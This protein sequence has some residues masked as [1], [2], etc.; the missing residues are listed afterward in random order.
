MGHHGVFLRHM[1]LSLP[2]RALAVLL[3]LAVS[4]TAAEPRYRGNAKSRVY[5]HSSCRYF[6]CTNCTVQL[7]ST[8]EAAARGFRACGICGKPRS[9]KKQE[10]A[11]TLSGNAKTRKFHRA[12]CRYA[13]CANCTAK[14]KTRQQAIEAGF[15]AGGCCNP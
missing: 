1:T 14:F 13:S 2:R 11:A 3:L 6:H 12:S 9:E 10:A 8:E 7:A 4:A 5:H 15:R